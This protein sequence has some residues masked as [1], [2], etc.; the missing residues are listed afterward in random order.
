[1]ADLLTAPCLLM[2]NK[3]GH[4][5]PPATLRKHMD[6]VRA[7]WDG[8]VICVRERITALQRGE[9]RLTVHAASESAARSRSSS[10]LV[11]REGVFTAM[12]DMLPS[13]AKAMSR[14]VA[15]CHGG[16]R[17]HPRRRQWQARPRRGICFRTPRP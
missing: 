14:M 16:L 2:V 17:R 1:M 12:G 15:A 5:A 3:D 8:P 6:Q 11:R 13:C 10:V 9:R 4:E 7:K